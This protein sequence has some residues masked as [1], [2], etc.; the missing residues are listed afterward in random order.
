M[1][2]TLTTQTNNTRKAILGNKKYNKK[3]ITETKQRA[4]RKYN[5]KTTHNREK[6]QNKNTIVKQ[7]HNNK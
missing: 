5:S 3:K 7:K 6:K 4:N 1:Q 2:N